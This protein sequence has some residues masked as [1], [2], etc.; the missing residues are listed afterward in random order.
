MVPHPPRCLP[1]YR[2]MIV[3]PQ[4]EAVEAGAS[5]LR[6]GGTA[7]DAVIACALTQGVVDPMMCGLG[8]LGVL[9]V[10]DPRTGKQIVLDGLSV[11][12]AACTETMWADQFKGECPDGFGYIIRDHANEPRPSCRHRARHPAHARRG[13]CPLW[14][15]GLVFA[16]RTGDRLRRGRLARSPACRGDVPPR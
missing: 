7:I 9:H 8:G 1:A 14:S 12:P 5:V 15:P 11:S 16:L 10:H 13:A 4:P 3:A 6:A 2:A